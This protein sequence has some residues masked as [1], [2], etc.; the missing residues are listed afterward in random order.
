MKQIVITRNQYE[1]LK[2]VFDAET[3]A[4]FNRAISE[5]VDKMNTQTTPLEERSIPL[6]MVCDEPIPPPVYSQVL[7][8][9]SMYQIGGF[10]HK[11]AP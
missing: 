6:V 5:R 7:N 3:I 10:G 2:E 1:K 9:S 8:T 11:P 4:F